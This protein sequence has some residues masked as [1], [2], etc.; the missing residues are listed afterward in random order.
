MPVHPLSATPGAPTGGDFA[1]LS[2][3]VRRAGLLDR[4]YA[5]YVLAMIGGCVAF[6]MVGDS[7]WQLGTAVFFAVMFA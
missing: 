3:L 7:W 1:D 5:Y 2:R 4:R 6:V